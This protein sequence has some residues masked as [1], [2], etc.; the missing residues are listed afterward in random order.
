MLKLG[1][2]PLSVDIR[3]SN[4]SESLPFDTTLLPLLLLCCMLP[5]VMGRGGGGGEQ[6][7]ATMS[8]EMDIWFTGYTLQEA[9][10][11]AIKTVDKLREKALAEPPKKSR[12]PFSRR[13]GPEQRYVVDRTEPP[14][15]YRV[16]DRNDG[17]V[18]FE[19]SDAEGG[20]TQVKTTFTART[21][22]M[23]QTL[24][25]EMPV[26][27]LVF[28]QNVCP[29]CGKQKQSEWQICPYCGTKYS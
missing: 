3:E 15:L 29:S 24:K 13:K 21:R 8:T 12:N 10:D 1:T 20:G 9:Y 14:R 18:I 11:H 17:P 28:A 7:S 4:M 25:S 6:S 2:G 26:R 16:T 19:L 22:S 23:I 27:K 5:L